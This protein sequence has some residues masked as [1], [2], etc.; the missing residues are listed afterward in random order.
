MLQADL[1]G[2]AGWSMKIE[3]D[4]VLSGASSTIGI[5]GD[6]VY[7]PLADAWR[8]VLDYLVLKAWMKITE[9][10]LST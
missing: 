7:R 4:S 1:L 9:F 2:N 5:N 3:G 10:T 6:P 8:E